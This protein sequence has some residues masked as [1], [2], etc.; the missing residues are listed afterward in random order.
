MTRKKVGQFPGRTP[1]SIAIPAEDSNRRSRSL[2][3]RSWI[4]ADVADDEEEENDESGEERE[5]GG[6]TI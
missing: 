4:N 3:T 2:L 6:W 5:E 1:E